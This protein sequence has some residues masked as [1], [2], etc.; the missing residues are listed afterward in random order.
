MAAS[1]TGS[2]GGP[3]LAE[4]MSAQGKYL[5]IEV[6]NFNNAASASDQMGSYLHMGAVRDLSLAASPSAPPATGEDLAGLVT[7]F[8]DDT[9][10]R[11]GC[12]DFVPEGVRQAETAKLHTKGGWR[13]HSDGNR[14]T[15][16]RGDKVEIIKGNYRMLVLGRQN[17][18]AG[19]DISGGHN[20]PSG[21]TYDGS[22]FIEYTTAEYGGT[23][24][25]VENTRKGH[26]HTAYHGRVY[27]FYCGEMVESVTG[28][29]SPTGLKPNPQ[30]LE[31]TW[32]ESIASYTGSPALPVPSI[33]SET[34]AVEIGSTTIADTMSDTTQ[35]MSMTSTTTCPSITVTTTGNTTS[36]TTGNTTSTTTGNTTS[37]TTGNTTDTQIGNSLQTTIGSQTQILVGNMAQITVG[38]MENITVGAVLDVLIAGKL[39]LNLALGF[40]FTANGLFELNPVTREDVGAVV[41]RLSEEHTSLATLKESLGSLWTIN[42]G[43]VQIG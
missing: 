42:F 31:K 18:Q 19:V 22:S 8:I 12:P 15:T 33:Y 35:A 20:C 21:I 13:D 7:T 30:V 40:Q 10:K 11:D 43:E 34:W 39:D 38:A 36:T 25:V 29:E 2:G 27:D 6:P 5:R 32:A 24:V 26:V 17:D 1:P 14:V 4:G 41:N 16:T 23:W 28:T 9:R 37:T 3:A